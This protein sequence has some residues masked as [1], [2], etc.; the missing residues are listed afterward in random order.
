M[1]RPIGCV[2]GVDNGARLVGEAE[3]RVAGPSKSG[4]TFKQ[5]RC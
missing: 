4:G 5:V 1:N 3:R 2:D